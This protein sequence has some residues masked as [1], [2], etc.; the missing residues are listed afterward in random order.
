LSVLLALISRE[1]PRFTNCFTSIINMEKPP[2]SDY[3]V[4]TGYSTP[5]GWN[6]MAHALLASTHEYLM[7]LNDDH[8]YPP[9]TI[10]RLMAR[11]KDVITGLYLLRQYPFEPVIYDY[12]DDLGR[13]GHHYLQPNESGLIKIK[14][15]GDGALL[16]HRSV[17]EKLPKWEYMGQS[18]WYQLNGPPSPP[19]QINCDV[20]FCER[21]RNAGYEIWCDL[22]VRVAHIACVPIVA[23][24][25]N[26]AWVSRMLQGNGGGIDVAAATPR[27]R[28]A[29]DADIANAKMR[30]KESK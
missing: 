21:L 9:D 30:A 1:I 13:M 17:F 14:V 18:G 5:Q 7:T 8:I 2:N 12:L 3:A 27:D 23:A 10:T 4:H 28:A 16:T 29:M 25:D 6:S 11:Q 24:L 20:L 19:D 26:G 15:C 22:D